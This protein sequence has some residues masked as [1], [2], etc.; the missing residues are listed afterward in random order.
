MYSKP[1]LTE[2]E[3]ENNLIAEDTLYQ[4]YSAF[5]LKYGHQPCRTRIF[6]FPI[7]RLYIVKVKDPL[8]ETFAVFRDL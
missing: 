7:W 2:P 8:R 6:K 5:T 1:N 4:E 3:L